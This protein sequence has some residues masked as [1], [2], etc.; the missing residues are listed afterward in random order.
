M[1]A[2]RWFDTISVDVH[3]QPDDFYR[4][5]HRLI[6][7]AMIELQLRQRADRHADRLGAAWPRPAC[8]RRPA[9]RTTSRRSSTRIPSLG[10]TK[11]YGQIVKENSLLRGLL[12]A[13]QEIQESIA[14]REGDPKRAA[15]ARPAARLRGR[16]GQPVRRARA[17]SARSCTKNSTKLE[18]QSLARQRR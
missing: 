8:S 14:T 2:E 5:R 1:L 12:R 18:K 16:P 6:F 17:R 11:Q 15:R 9:A 13:S 7:Q 4:P 10:N 3:L